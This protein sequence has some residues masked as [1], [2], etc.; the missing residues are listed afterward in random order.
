[1]QWPAPHSFMVGLRKNFGNE[2]R[3]AEET[4]IHVF[5]GV[6][7]YAGEVRDGTSSSEQRIKTRPINFANDQLFANP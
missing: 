1:M 7:R 3:D 6:H 5:S 2:K 4:R